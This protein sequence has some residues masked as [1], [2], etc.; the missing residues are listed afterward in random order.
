MHAASRTAV[1][2]LILIVTLAVALAERTALRHYADMHPRHRFTYRRASLT[3]R[4]MVSLDTDDVHHAREIAASMGATL[5]KRFQAM[6]NH[7]VFQAADAASMA[8]AKDAR[9]LHL[10]RLVS[11]PHNKRQA[12][13]DD[14][15][16]DAQ[17]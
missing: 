5:V 15:A 16:F 10:E 8:A 6:P 12:L 1:T 3:D 14:P 7:F 13:P 2:A 4:W 9:V 17:W 11:R